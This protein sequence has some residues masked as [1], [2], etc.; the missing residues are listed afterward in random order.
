M[1]LMNSCKKA[2]IG[3]VAEVALLFSGLW[4]FVV[5]SHRQGLDMGM[6]AALASDLLP[7]E[8]RQFSDCSNASIPEITE[9]L[10]VDALVKQPPH[11]PRLRAVRVVV[12]A[13]LVAPYGGFQG[14]MLPPETLRLRLEFKSFARHA[15][16]A[17]AS[18]S[19]LLLLEAVRYRQAHRQQAAEIA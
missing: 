11:G 3:R 12:P 17:H 7:P 4:L 6:E 5:A 9:H 19:L 1:R 10:T 13:L 16:L 18:W 15:W 14:V 8:S 2:L